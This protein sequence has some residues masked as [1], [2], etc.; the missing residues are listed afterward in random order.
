MKKDMFMLGLNHIGHDASASLV[1]GGEVI[2]SAMEERFTR[3]KKC[4][5]FPINAINFCL[6]YAGIDI[7]DIEVITYYMDPVKLFEERIIHYLGRHYPKSVPIFNDMLNRALEVKDVENE[8]REKLGYH[9]EIYFCEHHMAHIASSFFLSKYEKCAAISIDGL[10]EITSTV[11]ADVEDNEIKVLKKIDFPHSLG[12]LYNA[13]THYL[14]FDAIQDAGKVMGLSAYG[15]PETYLD[16][17]RKVVLLK[18]NGEYELN[19]DY[20]E[21]PFRRDVWIS[22]RFIKTFGPK[23]DCDNPIEKRHKDVAAALQAMLEE[24]YLHLANYAKKETGKEYLCLSGGV[25]LNSVANGKLLEKQ[26]FKD[27]FIPPATGDDG[28]SIG[29]PLYY[30]F[31]VLKNKKRH[32]FKSAY[33]GPEYNEDEI[34]KA[35]KRFNLKHYKSEDVCSETARMLADNKIIGWFQGRMEIGPR[36]LGNRSIL[37]NPSLGNVKEILNARVKFREPF[38]PFAPSILIEDVDEWFEYNHPAPYMLFVFKIKNEK[39]KIIPGVTHIDGSGRLQTVRKE[40]NKKYYGLINEFKK[41][42][43]IPIVV[44]TSFNVKGEPIVNSPADAIRCFLGNGIDCLV[45]GDYIIKKEDIRE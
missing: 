43:G 39:Q 12:M 1:R 30:N 31:I 15:N 13:V 41:L 10:G 44:N 20:F 35:I 23:R 22:D 29:G 9:K 45:M 7:D 40:D 16:E 6:D 21:Y 3:V 19:L 42:T 17:F 33:L 34:V 14:G 36:A 18:E 24:T 26:I 32:P 11:I 37:A 27:I 8:I 5:D 4:R 38:R 28:T 25:V 2:A